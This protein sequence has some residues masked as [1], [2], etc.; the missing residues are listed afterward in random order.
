MDFMNKRAL[1][2]KRNSM[3]EIDFTNMN[4]KNFMNKRDLMNKMNF[5]NK[6]DFMN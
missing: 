5:M 2:I 4:K 3:K 1:V 6:K